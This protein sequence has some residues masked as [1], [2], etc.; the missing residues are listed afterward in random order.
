MTASLIHGAQIHVNNAGQVAFNAVL[1]TDLNGD[2]TLDTGLF[3][4]SQGS[5]RLVART[6]TVITGLGTVAGLVTGPNILP[7]PPV[8][9]PNSSAIN[10][11]H[12]QV[13]FVATFSDGR[14]VLLVATPTP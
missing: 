14:N 5:V 12:G 13:L 2:G 7:A 10:N 1:S 4:W 3:A 6:G 11:D 8:L 9:P